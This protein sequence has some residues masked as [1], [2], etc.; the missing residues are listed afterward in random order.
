MPTGEEAA[1]ASKRRSVCRS[2]RT[3]STSLALIA[4][5]CTAANS[6]AGPGLIS[7]GPLRSATSTASSSSRGSAL[8][9]TTW[10]TPQASAIGRV[11]G[12]R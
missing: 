9:S 3:F 4:R 6:S 2:A 5:A 10:E 8:R 7:T 12:S 11:S 1:I